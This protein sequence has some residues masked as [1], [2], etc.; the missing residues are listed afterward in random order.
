MDKKNFA[1]IFNFGFHKDGLTINGKDFHPLNWS[2]NGISM[3]SDVST[4]PVNAMDLLETLTSVNV[5]QATKLDK[6]QALKTMVNK[7]IS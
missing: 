1:K 5:E 2:Y 6:L 3:E 7:I 4:K